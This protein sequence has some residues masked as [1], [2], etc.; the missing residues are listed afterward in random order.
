[1][2]CVLKQSSLVYFTATLQRVPKWMCTYHKSIIVVF[3]CVWVMLHIY[4]KRRIMYVYNS[5]RWGPLVRMWCMRY[6]AKHSY[7]KRMAHVVHNFK[8]ISK[9][10]AKRHQRLM[11]YRMSDKSSYLVPRTVYSNG[12]H[13]Y[14]TVQRGLSLQKLLPNLRLF[15]FVLFMCPNFFLEIVMQ[16]T[17]HTKIVRDSTNSVLFSSVTFFV[18]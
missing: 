2:E 3:V 6:E 15:R 4:L 18:Q 12:M 1:M 13:I 9:S 17:M 5:V 8:N 14:L 10:V 16:W 11:C 7:F